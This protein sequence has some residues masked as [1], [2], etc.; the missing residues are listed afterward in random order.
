MTVVVIVLRLHAPPMVLEE[1]KRPHYQEKGG[2]PF[3]FY[4][5]YGP[6]QRDVSLSP[7][8]RSRGLPKGVNVAHY[9]NDRH[10]SVI[11]GF[12]EGFIW[13]QLVHDAPELAAQIA[14]AT[15]CILLRG[16]LPDSP[17]LNYLRDVIGVLTHFLDHGGICVFDPQMYHWWKPGDWR[18]RIFAP[19]GSVPRHHVKILFSE[20]PDNASTWF[21]TTGMRKFGRPD[22]S[23]HGV[24]PALKIAVTDLF[25]RF[26]ELM[27]FG[28]VIPEGQSL[29]VAALPTGMTCHHEGTVDDP[30]FNNTH[31]EIRWP[32]QT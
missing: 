9:G 11:S 7:S 3:L 16:N 22:L 24:T 26:I 10:A 14:S 6:V 27:A 18:E 25:H 1:W 29:R 5:V 28:A 19:A 15:E 17:D 20:E 31:L 32:G 13:N 12:R 2:D 23:L 4:V 21:R 8:Y 30:L